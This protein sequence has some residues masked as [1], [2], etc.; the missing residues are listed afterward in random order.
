[1]K[2]N[3]VW[4]ALTML[5]FVIGTAIAFSSCGKDD[6]KGLDANNNQ[7]NPSNSTNTNSSTNSP[8]L[9]YSYSCLYDGQIDAD[10]YYSYVLTLSF[11]S[12]TDCKI[13]KKGSY[14]KYESFK[15]RVTYPEDIST[16]AKYTVSGNKITIKNCDPRTYFST[17]FENWDMTLTILDNGDALE[18]DDRVDEIWGNRTPIK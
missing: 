12:T 15:G 14:T 17:G 10:R 18:S 9:Y 11:I 1:M 6:D 4:S 8:I 3:K 7:N 2:N 5:I 13:K 16:T